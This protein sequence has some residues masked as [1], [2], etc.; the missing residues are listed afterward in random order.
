[1]YITFG[2]SLSGPTT[3]L[4]N[5]WSRPFPPHYLL[6]LLVSH[7]SLGRHLR[8]EI[9]KEAFWAIFCVSQLLLCNGPGT[10]LPLIVL[11]RILSTISPCTI[12]YVESV[13]RVTSLSLTAR[14][15]NQNCLKRKKSQKISSPGWPRPL[16]T[17]SWCNG[18]N[19]LRLIRTLLT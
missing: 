11:A 1:M 2:V 14:W 7:L 9:G 16:S 6:P 4:A 12:V 8:F 15:P 3:R 19:W 5:L 18:R 17:R 10:C 13:C